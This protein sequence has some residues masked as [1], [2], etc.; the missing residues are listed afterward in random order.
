[1]M[2][3][4]EDSIGRRG[5]GAERRCCDGANERADFGVPRLRGG[6]GLEEQMREDKKL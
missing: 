5:Q 3:P 2:R 1:M 4:N 6:S